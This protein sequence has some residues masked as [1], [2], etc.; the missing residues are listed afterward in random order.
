MRN[1]WKENAL[2]VE[3]EFDGSVNWGE[4]FY[5]CPE[6]GEPIYG[7]DWSNR[8]LLDFICPICEWEGD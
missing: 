4:E 5:L 8:D 1:V 6:C 3:Q 7:C 2:T